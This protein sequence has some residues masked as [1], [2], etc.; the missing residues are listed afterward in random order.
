M[1]VRTLARGYVPV[2]TLGP[3]GGR[4]GDGPTSIWRKERVYI[5]VPHWMGRRTNL[6]KMTIS[7]R[8]GPGVISAG[9]GVMWLHHGPGPQPK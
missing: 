4:F 5:G 6:L 9:G 3:K 7:A 1:L 2:R 8:G